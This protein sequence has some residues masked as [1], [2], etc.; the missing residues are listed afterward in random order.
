MS[1]KSRIR[2][3][4]FPCGH[5]GLGKYCHRCEDE[6]AGR[7]KV[8]QPRRTEASSAEQP[9]A[10]ERPKEYWNRAKCP[11]CGGTRVKKN[12]LNVFS[13]M[14][15]FEYTCTSYECGKSFN[16]D[17][18]KEYERVEAKPRQDRR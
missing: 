1:H 7:L 2:K 11:F 3:K 5:Q 15:A 6:K 17:Q 14:K 9:V 8:S 4:K 13:D 16:S 10:A 18:V 12:D